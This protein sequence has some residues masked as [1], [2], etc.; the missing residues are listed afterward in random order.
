[1]AASGLPE[2]ERRAIAGS[3]ASERARSPAEV[4]GV[5]DLLLRAAKSMSA[6]V[7]ENPVDGLSRAPSVIEAA[8]RHI[9]ANIGSNLR[10]P[11]LAE[12]AGL[13]GDRFARLFKITTGQT[14]Q[15]YLNSRRVARARELLTTT[16]WRVSEI[17]FAC[18]YDSLSHFNRMFRRNTGMSPVQF[19]AQCTKGTGG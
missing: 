5:A 16:D 7:P 10:V 15:A 14:V 17:A 6:P 3:R 19:R 8:L 11:D 18:G 2:A 9:E 1:M 12:K 4:A 13:G